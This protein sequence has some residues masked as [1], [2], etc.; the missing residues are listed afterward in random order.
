MLKLAN[1]LRI[2]VNQH[3]E[4]MQTMTEEG[5]CSPLAETKWSRKQVLGHLIDSAVNNHQRFIRVQL[6]EHTELPGYQQEDWVR[7]N[8]YQEESWSE[9][10]ELWRSIN[11]HLAHV[12]LRI[13]ADALINTISLDGKPAM[14]LK[15]VAEDYV[16]HLKHH[17][18]QMKL[19]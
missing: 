7:L 1:E 15:F 14:T 9:L 13:S 5:S 18:A 11:V 3:I 12:L 10:I 16:R 17:L 19:D 2:I 4:L 6:R 8:G